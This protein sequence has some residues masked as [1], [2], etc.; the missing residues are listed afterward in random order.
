M[1][2][3][4]GLANWVSKLDQVD[5][6]FQENIFQQIIVFSNS[7]KDKVASNGIRGLG[8]YLQKYTISESQNIYLEL[9]NIFI[10]NLSHKSPKVC[11]NA[12]VA[13]QN[14]LFSE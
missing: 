4:W 6:I 7:T 3:A 5:H 13:I 11:W 1:K 10:K 12:C 9:L 8:Y 14:I 2:I